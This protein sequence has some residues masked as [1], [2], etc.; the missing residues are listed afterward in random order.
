MKYKRI[1]S[2]PYEILR[3]TLTGNIHVSGFF[4][5]YCKKDIFEIRRMIAMNLTAIL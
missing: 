5:F 1:F 4:D 2:M 3:N